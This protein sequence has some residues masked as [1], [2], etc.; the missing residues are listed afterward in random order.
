[1]RQRLKLFKPHLAM[2]AVWLAVSGCGRVQTSEQT[3]P[4]PHVADPPAIAITEIAHEAVQPQRVH[5]LKNADDK[6]SLGAIYSRCGAA[7]KEYLDAVKRFRSAAASGDASAQYCLGLMYGKGEGV[8]EDYVAAV[9]W[10][11][12]AADHGFAPAQCALGECYAEAK[13]VA[14]DSKHAA[15]W[16]RKASDQGDSTAQYNIGVACSNGDGVAQDYDEAVKWFRRAADQGDARAQLCLAACFM[17]GQGVPLDYAEAVKWFRKAAD[18]GDAKAQLCL[19]I[20]YFEGKAAP[21]DLT[22]AYKWVNLIAAKSRPADWLECDG[23]AA[24]PSRVPLV[25]INHVMIARGETGQVR[26]PSGTIKITCVST[27]PD[28]ASILLDGEKKPRTLKMGSEAAVSKLVFESAFKLRSA[29]AQI[30]TAKQVAEG[31]RRSSAFTIDTECRSRSDDFLPVP[32]TE[33]TGTVLAA[34]WI[35]PDG[36]FGEPGPKAEATHQSAGTGFFVT[37]DGYLVTCEHVVRGA[38]SF[39]IQT[40]MGSIPAQL[41]KQDRT[42]DLA[43]L[44]VT[45]TFQALPIALEARAKLGDPVFTIGFPNYVVQGVAP[46]LTRG[47]ISSLAGIRDNPHYF[48]I[49]VPVQPGNSGGALLDERGNVLGVVALRLNDMAT[50]Q[51]SGALPQNVNYAIK[52][53]GVRKFLKDI[54]ELRNKLKTPSSQSNRETAIASG[55]SAAVLVLADL[56]PADSH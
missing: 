53:E 41:V 6:N 29:F 46:K 17:K 28:S 51:T 4:K 38:C 15:E 3:Q 39:R 18:Q 45:G 2:G 21:R 34:V 36:F 43:L 40:P 16:F 13:G 24:A 52:S 56:Q 50:L 19:S 54:P 44:K 55:E 22:E 30:M 1:M 48:Q 5:Q 31:Q 49:S 42:N 11:R 26:T 23:I 8:P 47:E 9:K 37:D 10:F 25:I 35:S 27:D 12:S 20:I 32:E 14:Q 7:S 33:M